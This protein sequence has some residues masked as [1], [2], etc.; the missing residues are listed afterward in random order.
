MMRRLLA[1]LMLS[2]AFVAGAQEEK[3]KITPTARALFDVAAYAPS[4]SLFRPGVAIPDVRLGAKATFGPYEARADVSYRFGKLY[5]ADVYLQWNINKNSFLKGGFFVP[6][7]GLQFSTG[8]S[9]KISMEEPIAQ[10]VFGEIRLLGAMYVWHDAKFHFAGE[11]Y[12]QAEASVLHANEL[13]NTGVGALVR[14]AW[15]PFTAPGNIFQIGVSALGQS[16]RF[17]GDRE[18]PVSQFAANFPTRVNSVNLLKATVDSVS[19]IFKVT[20][21]LLWAKGRVGVESQFYYLYTGRRHNL[22]AFQGYGAYVMARVLLNRGAKYSYSESM[23]AMATPAPKSWELVAG[24]SWT[25]LNDS[26]AGIYGSEANSASLTLNYYLN[27]YITWRVNYTYA[28]R[29]E[30]PGLP[31][32]HANIFQTRIQFVF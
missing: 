17:S 18:N 26:R 5:L 4:D 6:Q 24:Y 32:R 22:P 10:S 2:V 28:N 8:A 16:P 27:K 19:G 21:E 29:I 1:F 31:A 20:P 3:F 25:N 9:H 12:A 11:L 15:H 7:F 30:E 13:G 23:A 14:F